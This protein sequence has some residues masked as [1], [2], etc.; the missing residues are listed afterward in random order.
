LDINWTS[1]ANG[2]ISITGSA[3]DDFFDAGRDANWWLSVGGT[4]IASRGSVYGLV[5]S[6]VAAQFSDN[7]LP[8]YTL[9]GIS[10]TAG[11]VVEFAVAADTYYGHFVG[12]REDITL[13]VTQATP[14]FSN[15]S[16]SQATIY[17][18]TAITLAGKVSAT[19]PIYPA[20]GE[21]IT[22]TI[23][24]NAQTTTINDSTG[25]FSFS[26]NP[27]TIPASATPYTIIYSYGG[28]ASLN[29]ANNSSTTLTVNQATPVITWANP[30]PIAVGTALSGVQLD[31][32]TSVPGS[33]AYNPPAGTVLPAGSGQTLS[34]TF[35][36]DNT[37]DY[38][39]ATATVKINVDPLPTP[40]VLV[41]PT[42]ENTAV[43][44]PAAKL[45]AV[46]KSGSGGALSITAV[47]SHSALGATV[48]L[49]GGLIT[50]TPVYNFTGADSFT[51]TLFDGL[52]SAQGTDPVTVTSTIPPSL[53]N[54][55]IV[56]SGNDVF[57]EFLGIPGF[58]Y[59]VQSASNPAGP[60]ADLSG[61]LTAG[62][63]G[64]ITYTD[65]TP[66]SP[67]FYRTRVGP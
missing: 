58:V 47:G 9:T 34:T 56:A 17:G 25:D 41:L 50:Y 49:A 29:A 14:S 62:A 28:D 66:Y 35:T 59:V 48:V 19:G 51:Y 40:G 57:L 31:A 60:W 43:S 61:P 55:S 33:F 54:L 22:V 4:I 64:L 16:A 65:T 21:T 12:I 15:L 30:P 3:W 18:T 13:T 37:G 53:N 36:P 38:T 23:N 8:G 24:G 44:L 39:T 1:P 27:S 20:Q 45:A 11:K 63:T 26:Y 2:V 42:T 46:G 67:E 5:R 32:S 52:G 6:D 7:L 10:V